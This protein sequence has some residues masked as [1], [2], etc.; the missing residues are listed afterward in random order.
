MADRSRVLI[1]EDNADLLLLYS[2]TMG[3][4][5]LEIDPVTS[6]ANARELVSR[7][8]YDLII[9]DMRLGG[10]HGTDLL[11]YLKAKQV[12]GMEVIIVSG[13]DHYRE[14]CRQLGF[15]LFLSKP[16]SM[17]ELKTLVTRLLT[18]ITQ[19]LPA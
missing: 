5:G 11:R 13:E 18:P 1:V 10:D 19:S 12:E 16:V 3:A 17:R 4:L 8:Q 9:C 14:A 15:D 7:R 6:L 2:K